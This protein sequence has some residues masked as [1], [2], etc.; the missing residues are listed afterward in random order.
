MMH[1]AR[2]IENLLQ[3]LSNF[4]AFDS[5]ALVNSAEPI[6]ADTLT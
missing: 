2:N 3:F 6:I 1:L 5:L 4:V